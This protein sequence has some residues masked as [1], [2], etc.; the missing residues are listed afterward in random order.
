MWKLQL[1]VSKYDMLGINRSLFNSDYCINDTILPHDTKC[2]NLRVM[3]TRDLSF[4]VRINA[5]TAKA[6]QE[7]N[8]ILHCF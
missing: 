3:I 7:A 4:A 8:C 5:I 2:R 6:H 1:F